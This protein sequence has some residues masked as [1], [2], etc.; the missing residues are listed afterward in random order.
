MLVAADR[1]QAKI[2]RRYI[3]GILST[4]LLTGLVENQTADTIDLKGSVTVEVVTRSYRTV[5]GRSVCVAMLGRAGLLAR[6]Q[7]RQPRH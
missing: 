4:P 3:V 2:L 1:E 7:F 5:R 6:R